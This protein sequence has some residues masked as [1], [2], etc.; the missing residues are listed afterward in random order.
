MP[1]YFI[2]LMQQTTIVIKGYVIFEYSLTLIAEFLI[3]KKA[4]FVL[5]SNGIPARCI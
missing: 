4:F 2:A 5:C 3:E 1:V